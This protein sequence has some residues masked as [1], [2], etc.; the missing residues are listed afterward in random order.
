M[1]NSKWPSFAQT[2]LVCCC[3]AVAVLAFG[4]VV[5]YAIGLNLEPMATLFFIAGCVAWPIVWY[6]LD[7]GS[8]VLMTIGAFVAVVFIQ[9][10]F[11]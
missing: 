2:P 3:S 11:A 9:V 4:W 10:L 5:Q 7:F 6:L 1:E 8:A